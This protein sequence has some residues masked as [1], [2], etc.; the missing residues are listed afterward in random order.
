MQCCK[1]DWLEPETSATAKTDEVGHKVK[2]ARLLEFLKL[3]LSGIFER[4]LNNNDEEPHPEG[5][6]LN[7]QCHLMDKK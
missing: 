7:A 1:G 6:I 5:H 4:N 3:D 2:E